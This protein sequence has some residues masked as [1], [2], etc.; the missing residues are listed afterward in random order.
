MVAWFEI[1]VKKMERAKSFYET[2]FD[3][4]ITVHDLGGFVM[5]WFPNQEGKSL[6][7]GS[8]VQHEHYSPS[9]TKGVLVYLSCDDLANELAKV[10]DAGGKIIKP[11]TEIG[12]GHGFMALII[13]SEGNSVAL[14]SVS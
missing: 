9:A 1:P 8:L 7:S 11:K 6:A 10:E 2:V 3:I 13:D 5:G 12:N 4:S 14:H